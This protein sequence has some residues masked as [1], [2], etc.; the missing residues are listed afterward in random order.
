MIDL[1]ISIP[2]LESLEKELAG[3]EKQIPFATALALTKTAKA[4]EADIRK[5][6][7]RVFDRPTR[8]TITGTLTKPATKRNLNAF[9]GLKDW[10]PK[11]GNARD[12]LQPH[13]YAGARSPKRSEKA[14]RQRGFLKSSEFLVPGRDARL[15]K[16]GNI[17]KAQVVKAMSNIGGQRDSAQ[18]SRRTSGRQYFWLPGAGIFFRQGGRLKSFLVIAKQPQYRKRFDFFGLSQASAAHHLPK[19]AVKAAKFAR[20]TAR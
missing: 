18:N 17:T 3:Y 8:F 10:A 4:V 14:L 13:I 9:V 15:N 11:G 1:N 2:G 12:Y 20:D 5:V 7:P 6:M 16:H 19:E